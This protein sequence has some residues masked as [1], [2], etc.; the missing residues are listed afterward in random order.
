MEMGHRIQTVL[1]Y[2]HSYEHK[3][4]TQPTRP[5]I[6]QIAQRDNESLIVKLFLLE[7]AAV[8]YYFREICYAWILEHNY[9][10]DSTVKRSGIPERGR[11][12]RSPCLP[13]G[14]SCPWL[15]QPGLWLPCKRKSTGPE[16]DDQTDLP[17]WH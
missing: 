5:F 4:T 10:R 17:F 1:Q 2:P 13:P 11:V 14:S 8:L 16:R 3:N 12:E 7:N 15:P 6:N 9:Q